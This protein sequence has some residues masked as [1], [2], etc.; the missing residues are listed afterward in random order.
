MNYAIERNDNMIND[1]M[2]MQNFELLYKKNIV[3]YGASAAGTKLYSWMREIGLNISCFCDSDP[4]KWNDILLDKKIISPNEL[5]N[6][7]QQE[8]I[9]IIISSCYCYEINLLLEK[10]KIRYSNVFSMGVFTHALFR[11]M[12]KNEPRFDNTRVW[13]V[14]H[15]KFEVETHSSHYPGTT[16]DN[17]IEYLYKNRNPIL[18]YQPGKVGS[19]SV[20]VS[21]AKYCDAVHIH[22]LHRFLD[23]QLKDLFP[24]DEKI[25]IVSLVRESMSRD[26]AMYFE[27][28]SIDDFFDVAY[29]KEYLEEVVKFLRINAGMTNV[30]STA[31]GVGSQFDWF[32]SEMLPVTGIDVY[33]HPFDRERGYEI[34]KKDNIELLLIKLECLDEMENVIKEFVGLRDFKLE[35]ANEGRFK[36]NAIL[37]QQTKKKITI[38]RDYVDNYYKNNSYMDHF[39][40]E[41]EKKTFLENWRKNI[42]G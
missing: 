37:Y 11:F 32:N 35:N 31:L 40:S 4:F 25:K 30:P 20:V 17:F 14:L 23:C 6:Y 33:A 34:I 21:L 5:K 26:L 10:L 36:W 19:C 12:K 2:L 29:E 16:Y 15:H 22:T 28:M 41:D 39:Y 9:T 1:F 18:V 13:Q 42:E 3:L 38:P 27:L 7:A 8:D 24:K